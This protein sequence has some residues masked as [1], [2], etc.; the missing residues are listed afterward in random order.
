MWVVT[1]VVHGRL[2]SCVGQNVGGC[3]VLIM[4]TLAAVQYG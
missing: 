4:A 2:N 3:N 1:T